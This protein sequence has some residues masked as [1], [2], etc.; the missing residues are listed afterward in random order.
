M[1]Y[2]QHGEFIN[3]RT[4]ERLLAYQLKSDNAACDSADGDD[5]DQDDCKDAANKNSDT[6]DND[7]VAGSGDD[8]EADNTE[9]D[10]KCV[11]HVSVYSYNLRQVF[12]YI[13]V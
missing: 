13:H 6:N 4:R 10:K 7:C 5:D 9:F 3:L 11:T 2:Q 1:V 8:D 12:M